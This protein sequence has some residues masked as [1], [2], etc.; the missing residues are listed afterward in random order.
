M[1]FT[2]SA[3]EHVVIDLDSYR[4]NEGLLNEVLQIADQ[5]SVALVTRYREQEETLELSIRTI[6]R[7]KNPTEASLFQNVIRRALETLNAKPSK[8]VFISASGRNLRSASEL[9]LGTAVTKKPSMSTEELLVVFEN[10]PDFILDEAKDLKRAFSGDLIGYGG[11]YIAA[12]SDCVIF[13]PKGGVWI[14]YP[15]AP[16]EEYPDCPINIAGR[17][18]GYEDPRHELHALSQ[19]IIGSKN[20]P[21]RQIDC[22][23]NII[24]SAIDC[25][26]GGDFDA[27]T[28]IPARPGA[29]NRLNLFLQ[30]LPNTERLKKIEN[31]ADKIRPDLI[32][33]V[34]TYPSLKQVKQARLRRLAL[35]GAFEASKDAQGKTIVLID[36]VITTGSTLNEAIKTLKSAGAKRVIPIALGYHPYAVRTLALEGQTAIACSCSKELVR[37]NNSKTGEPFYGCS[38]YFEGNKH[39]TVSLA[40]AV[41]MKLEKIEDIVMQPDEELQSEGIEF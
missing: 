22:F 4:Q 25:I 27:I 13:H 16:N 18:F 19:R 3:V 41:E 32:Q 36:D 26:T 5:H 7:P 37:R 15:A 33:A 23:A 31:L 10:F 12:P 6:I 39:D 17:Y 9:L 11:E 2:I 38:G 8:T 40:K 34:K 1:F 30:H 14:T 21:E 29:D 35:N 28:C 20:K 24:A